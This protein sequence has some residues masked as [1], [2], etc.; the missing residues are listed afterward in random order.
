MDE[1]EGLYTAFL[2]LPP[3][4]KRPEGSALDILPWR[5]ME[6]QARTAR[7]LRRKEGGGDERSLVVCWGG[8]G[9]LDAGTTTRS[10]IGSGRHLRR[11]RS[12]FLDA[13]SPGS[14]LVDLLEVGGVESGEVGR[15]I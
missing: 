9:V 8:V 6:G 4:W 11:N 5:A 1:V 13:S 2:H 7:F 10:L 15:C 12:L 3:S 14:Y